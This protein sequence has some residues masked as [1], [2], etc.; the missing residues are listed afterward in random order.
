[1]KTAGFLNTIHGTINRRVL[2]NYR[3][4]PAALKGVLP[5]PFVPKLHGGYG[6]GGVC[7]I[8][9]QGLRPRGV[10]AWLGLG[11]EN[12]AHR[13]AVCWTQDGETREGVYIPRRD[14]DSWFNK[15]LGGR[16]FPGI[17]NRGRFTADESSDRVRVAV[18]S[19][20]GE[21]AIAFA[22]RAAERLP[23]DSVFADT[24]A[25]AGFFSLGATGYSATRQEGRF[26]G[27]ELHSLDWRVS[28][29]AI[30]QEHSSFFDDRERFPPGS[31]EPDCALLMRNIAH[32]W[33]SRPDLYTSE[34]REELVTQ[35]A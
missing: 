31:I 12:A 2:L 15:M 14:T 16:V 9:F 29:L 33:R 20:D 4:D 34:T 13:V 32:E 22:G 7:M 27:M 23:E 26:H 6:I 21:T 17:F 11:S 10:P 18:R 35:K 3:I 8:R 25:A 19:R 28:P 5:R 1:M 30:E 24:D